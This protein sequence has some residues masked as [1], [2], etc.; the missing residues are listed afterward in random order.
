MHSAIDLELALSLPWRICA[1]QLVWWPRL[2]LIFPFR[3]LACHIPCADLGEED[4]Q[5][6]PL[7]NVNSLILDKV[8]EYCKYHKVIECSIYF[9]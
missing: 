6:I 3:Q 7:P 9:Y 1:R 4:D 8:I 5:P 2:K